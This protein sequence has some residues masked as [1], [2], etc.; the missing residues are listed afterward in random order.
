MTIFRAASLWPR[1]AG[2]LGMLFI[3]WGPPAFANIAPLG[4]NGSHE[5]GIAAAVLAVPGLFV[6]AMVAPLVGY[7]RRDW[8]FNFCPPIG[9]FVFYEIGA[10]MAELSNQ[11][12]QPLNAKDESASALQ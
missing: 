10:R 5:S 4:I 6:L 2:G 12:P 9:I 11:G 3:V 1:K 7:R 8:L